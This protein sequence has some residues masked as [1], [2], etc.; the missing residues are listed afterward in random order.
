LLRPIWIVLLNLKVFWKFDDSFLCFWLIANTH[1]FETEVL[2]LFPIIVPMIVFLK[3]LLFF[4]ESLS[5]P[6]LDFIAFWEDHFFDS[7]CGL[8]ALVAIDFPNIG[9]IE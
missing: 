4:F 8:T 5:I 3:T 9:E 7:Y 2:S 1:H 6:S